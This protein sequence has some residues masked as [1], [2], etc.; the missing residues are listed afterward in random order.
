MAPEPHTAAPRVS[1]LLPVRNG[2][3][4]LRR[5]V[6]SILC[7]DYVNFELIVVDDGSTDGSTEWLAAQRDARIVLLRQA[8]LGLVGAL[9]AG[10]AAARGAY[11]ARMDADDEADPLRLGA[12]VAHLDRHPDIGVLFTDASYIDEASAVVGSERGRGVDET[13]VREG[14]LFRTHRPVL[15]HPSVMIRRGVI[16]SVGGYRDYPAAEDADLWLRL[17]RT[18]RIR[19]LD[20]ALL[21]YRKLAS[22]V[23]RQRRHE[24]MTNTALAAV[25]FLVEDAAGLDLYRSRRDAWETARVRLLRAT[26][27]IHRAEALRNACVGALREKRWSTLPSLAA[28]MLLRSGSLCW[29]HRFKER[30]L[31]RHV[32]TEARLLAQSVGTAAALPA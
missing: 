11:I 12:Q 20:R 10:L 28:D 19:Q 30:A 4:Y 17:S 31:R 15:I 25:N 7:Q 13:S 14:L 8:A 9:N 22:S 5:A 1:V 27:P 16:A 24:Q 3:A 29:L 6:G 23:S 21:R 2:G 26:E 18:T 32:E